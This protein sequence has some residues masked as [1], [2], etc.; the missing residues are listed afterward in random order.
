MPGDEAG[1]YA[2]AT[3]VPAGGTFYDREKGTLVF[4]FDATRVGDGLDP[5]A[6]R[7][8]FIAGIHLNEGKDGQGK[9]QAR[10]TVNLTGASQYSCR[11]EKDADSPYLA[12]RFNR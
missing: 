5:G 4:H 8:R 3:R 1:F 9:P 11:V 2:D 10:V 6:L 12:V 7:N